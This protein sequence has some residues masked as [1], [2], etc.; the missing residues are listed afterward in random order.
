[1]LPLMLDRTGQPAV[2]TAI[3]LNL[4]FELF[5]SRRCVSSFFQVEPYFIF[6]TRAHSAAPAFPTSANSPQFWA[7][8]ASSPPHFPQEQ[9]ISLGLFN[10]I[11]LLL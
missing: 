10:L 3:L 9:S 8:S 2:S 11:S 5:F 4:C 6:F 1:M 7:S